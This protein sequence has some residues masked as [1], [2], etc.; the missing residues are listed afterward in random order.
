MAEVKILRRRYL[1]DS[2]CR[3]RAAAILAE[4]QGIREKGRRW[5]HIWYGGFETVKAKVEHLYHPEEAKIILGELEKQ[6]E[7]GATLGG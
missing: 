5:N 1:K 7:N 6:I 4:N 2:Q 3:Q